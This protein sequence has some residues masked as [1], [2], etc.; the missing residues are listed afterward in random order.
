MNMNI[1]MKEELADRLKAYRDG[2]IH[3]PSLNSIICLAIDQFL[4]SEASTSWHRTRTPQLAE[5]ARRIA[6]DT[7]QGWLDVAI[8]KASSLYQGLVELRYRHERP[9]H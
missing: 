7:E 5:L 6:N 4:K 3:K 8:Q 2:N 1:R 9:L